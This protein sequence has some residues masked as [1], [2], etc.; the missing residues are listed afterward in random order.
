M[1]VA[2]L[3]TGYIIHSAGWIGNDPLT[4]VIGESDPYVHISGRVS[5]FN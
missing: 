5:T 4:V 3:L 2:L 1:H